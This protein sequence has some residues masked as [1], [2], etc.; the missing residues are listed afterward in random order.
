MYTE[1]TQNNLVHDYRPNKR[2]RLQIEYSHI[3]I[4]TSSIYGITL[5][6]KG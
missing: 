4:L 6:N 1:E 3:P 2:F 5:R